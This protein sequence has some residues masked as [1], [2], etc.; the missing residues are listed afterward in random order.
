MT[1]KLPIPALAVLIFASMGASDALAD[2]GNEILEKVDATIMAP[3]DQTATVKMTLKDVDGNTKVRELL[4]K[5]KGSKLRLTRFIS[6]IAVKGVSFLVKSDEEMYLYMP[7]FGKIRRIASHVKNE[8]FMGTDFSYSDLGSSGWVNDYR[9]K[10]IEREGKNVLLELVPN[11]PKNTDYGKVTMLVDTATYL[12]LRIQFFDKKGALWKEMTQER[13]KKVSSYWVPRTVVMRDLKK[14]HST[15][16]E[17]K[18]ISF[19]TGLNDKEF[20]KRKLKRSR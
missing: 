1:R 13:I 20:S 12:P 10:V 17:M 5:Q 11:K 15:I 2:K 16:M 18:D 7:E 19:D 8:N 9:A 6:P 3:K 14:K 4:M